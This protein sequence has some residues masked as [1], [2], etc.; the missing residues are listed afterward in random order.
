MQSNNQY[1]EIRTIAAV[2]GMSHNLKSPFP[3]L[4]KD[5]I[6]IKG[7]QKGPLIMTAGEF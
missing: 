1:N 2:Q 5:E 6:K 7:L 4:G 3:C